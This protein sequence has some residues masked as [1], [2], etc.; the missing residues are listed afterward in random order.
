[1]VFSG[2]CY[3]KIFPDA[4]KWHGI[5]PMFV[6][7]ILQKKCLSFVKFFAFQHSFV[8]IISLPSKPLTYVV[9]EYYK[10]C[11]EIAS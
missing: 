7:N 4:K 2:A 5:T 10:S 11:V 3:E 1:M 9:F 6:N 8:L